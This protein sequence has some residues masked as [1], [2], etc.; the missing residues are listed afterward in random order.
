MTQTQLEQEHTDSRADEITGA[1]V[2]SAAHDGGDHS[3]LTMQEQKLSPAE[4][5]H[6]VIKNGVT[7][8]SVSVVER[9]VALQER[10][11][12]KAAEREFAAAFVK[13]QD[14]MPNI[15]KT[16]AVPGKEPGSIRYKYAPFE[17]IMESVKPVLQANGFTVSFSMSVSEGRVVQECTLTHTGGHS[18][19]NQFMARIGN[20]PPHSSEAQGDG[21]ASTYAKR[22]AL[23]DALNIVIE[24]DT[25]GADARKE[26]S[27]L[28]FEQAS[29][30][31]E[32]VAETGADEAK[33]L[34][35]AGAAKY[36]DI[37]SEKYDLC[38]AALGKKRRS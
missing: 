9:L 12:A 37:G 31:R 36:E 6:A 38:L 20:G 11:D 35:L 15:P 7:G 13:L 24:S 10:M 29:F 21:A 4:L 3:Q 19:K 14:D 1:A 28:S 17:D 8:E 33:F 25:D 30:L 18:R 26:G 5:I 16:K 32:Q 27:K 23:C 34:K 22:F 2:R